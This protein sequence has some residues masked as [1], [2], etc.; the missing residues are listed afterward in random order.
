[1]L[2]RQLLLYRT[3]GRNKSYRGQLWCLSVCGL[4]IYQA[5]KYLGGKVPCWL[6]NSYC[7]EKYGQI[8]HVA[9]CCGAYRCADCR[10]IRQGGTWEVRYS[11]GYKI[12]IIRNGR[13]RYIM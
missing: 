6:Q 1:V 5:S 4:K 11:F 7:T 12:V 8:Q 9:D 2:V 13:D 3:V 10:Y